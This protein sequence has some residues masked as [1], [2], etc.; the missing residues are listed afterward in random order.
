MTPFAVALA[1]LLALICTATP[2]NAAAQ[3]VRLLPLSGTIGVPQTAAGSGVACGG[4]TYALT[5]SADLRS[6]TSVAVQGF[7]AG[8]QVFSGSGT[9][10]PGAVPID[11][12]RGSFQ[13]YF[14]GRE[15][16]Q[17]ITVSGN[18]A[19]GPEYDPAFALGGVSFAV[20]PSMCAQLGLGPP[21]PGGGLPETGQGASRS[22][23][24]PLLWLGAAAALIGSFLGLA[25]ERRLRR[26]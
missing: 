24:A 3:Q 15:P 6:I 18:F 14:P 5:R 16:G 12:E 11:P 21:L 19:L 13:V 8:D 7:Q 4:G 20:S 2:R 10:P 17:E 23:A 9:F 22:S 25:S 1:L 26:P